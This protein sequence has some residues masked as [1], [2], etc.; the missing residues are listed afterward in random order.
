MRLTWAIV[1]NVQQEHQ[2]VYCCS[3]DA[4]GNFGKVPFVEMLSRCSLPFVEMLSRKKVV[5]PPLSVPSPA[6]STG[7]TQQTMSMD[8]INVTHN[9]V[10]ALSDFTKP[11][12]FYL[13]KSFS[14]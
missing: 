14:G 3:E 4:N 2:A 10:L 9:L 7:V 11:A 13:W 5:S 8:T 1:P 12:V 6:L